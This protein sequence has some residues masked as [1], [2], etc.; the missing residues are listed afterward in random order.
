MADNETTTNTAATAPVTSLSAGAV[1]RDVLTHDAGVAAITSNVYPII[2]DEATLPYVLYRRT[3]LDHN[4]SKAGAPG[5]DTVRIEVVCYAATYA[6]S[7]ALA[8]AVRAALD[9]KQATVGTMTM[10][11]CFLESADETWEDD[12]YG[13]QLI[14]NVKI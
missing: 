14:F 3:S 12:A 7:I 6:G 1:I 11:G 13:Q 8:E 10:R 2:T 5:A 9:Y 4:T